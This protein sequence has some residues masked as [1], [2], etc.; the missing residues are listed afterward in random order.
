MESPPNLKTCT[1]SWEKWPVQDLKNVKVIPKLDLKFSSNMDATPPERQIK[2]RSSARQLVNKFSP[3]RTRR[4]GD[5][6]VRRSSARQLVVRQSVEKLS[7]QGEKKGKEESLSPNLHNRRDHIKNI[8]KSYRSLSGEVRTLRGGKDSKNARRSLSEPEKI[9]PKTEEKDPYKKLGIRKIE[10][11]AYFCYRIVS[12]EESF[13]WKYQKSVESSTSNREAFFNQ[14]VRVNSKGENYHKVAKIIVEI[15]NPCHAENKE[16]LRFIKEHHRADLRLAKNSSESGA[17]LRGTSVA[18]EVMK[19][20]FKPLLS[21]VLER[22]TSRTIEY[23]SNIT[24]YSPI[25]FHDNQ[26]K[27]DDKKLVVMSYTPS[28]FEDCCDSFYEDIRKVLKLA[29]KGILKHTKESIVDIPEEVKEVYHDHFE[30]CGEIFP[31]QAHVGHEQITGMFILRRLNPYL[32]L[33]DRRVEYTDDNH[34]SRLHRAILCL[35]SLIQF[36]ANE[37]PEDSRKIP[38]SVKSLFKGKG[39]EERKKAL[40]DIISQISS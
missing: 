26:I 36:T 22:S 27:D 2:R 13:L 11:Q 14:F 4:K 40:R 6:I 1:D 10:S 20:V 33:T 31:D 9:K 8:F 24:K 28:N 23:L 19:I 12:L 37:V 16:I 30:Y 39:Y 21:E 18:S 15:L 5:K 7:P 17:L 25:V 29:L 38:P 32:I 34:S 3:R 35:S